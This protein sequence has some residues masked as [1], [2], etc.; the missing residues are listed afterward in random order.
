MKG[1]GVVATFAVI[2]LAL[3]LGLGQKATAQP[4]APAL[5][6]ADMRQSVWY[7]VFVRSFQ[8]SDGDGIGDLQGVRSRLP[9]LAELGIGGIW[10][11]PIHPSPSYHGY[12]VTDYRAVNPDYGD[13]D[14]LRALL[15]DAH[16]LG[17]RVILDFVPNHTSVMHPW[18]QKALAGDARYR[19]YYVWAED[20]PDWRG[21]GG[22]SAWHA[23]NGVHYLALFS[24]SM[25]DLNH[26]NPD[27]RQEMFDVARYWLEFGFDGFRVDAIQH[28]VEGEDGSI[29]NTAATYAW[30]A[31]FQAF[32]REVAPGAL[33]L[34]ETWTEM[35]AIVRYH[36]A[37]GL[38]MSFDYPLWR[39][40]LAAIQ[41]RS[42]SDLAFQLEQTLAQYP[43]TAARG[44]FLSN[45]DQTRHATQLS[46]PRRDERRLKLAASLLLTM[47]GT[48]FLYYGEEIGMPD[49]PGQFDVEKRTPMRW[50]PAAA[51]GTFG[52]STVAPWT[53][54][55]EAIEGV[56]VAEQRSD[57]SS[58]WSWYQRLIALRGTVPALRSN[59]AEVLDVGQRAVLSLR[60]G[61]G[62]DAVVVLVNLSGRALT[63]SLDALGWQTA[64]D[65]WQE[66]AP[67]AGVAEDAVLAAGELT[68]EGYGLRV[69]VQASSP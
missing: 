54:P 21:T 48:P 1:R 47:P 58:V 55:G 64:R 2:G 10:L 14:D 42:A 53:D 31:E 13:A 62:D 23:A 38:D 26:T 12:D 8:D 28:I 37:S 67:E 35:P 45:H 57:P 7:E 56:S 30:V 34:G 66:T 52:F 6:E 29:R 44:V 40:T 49:G 15:D 3:A 19:D 65:I 22:G 63:V 41:A 32:V 36:E 69:L 59:E 5:P 24:A 51:D 27:V 20:P 18:F 25:P 17:M 33:V 39:T 46:F 16:A 60:R 50:E 43:P 11:M 9:Y 68:L 61:A 4:A